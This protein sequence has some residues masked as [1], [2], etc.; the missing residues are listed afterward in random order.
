MQHQ[1]SIISVMCWAG[2][3]L[4]HQQSKKQLN[5][6][7]MEL[8]HFTSRSLVQVCVTRA[9]PAT[10]WVLPSCPHRTKL[11]TP[12]ERLK[13]EQS[14]CLSP[15]DT[16]AAL[17]EMEM[18]LLWPP[19]K[20]ME[21]KATTVRPTT[22]SSASHRDMIHTEKVTSGEEQEGAFLH[23]VTCV[24]LLCRLHVRLQKSLFPGPLRLVPALLCIPL[25]PAQS[26]TANPTA[27]CSKSTSDI[28]PLLLLLQHCKPC[29]IHS[30]WWSW[31]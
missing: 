23:I 19:Q 31:Y 11:C 15:S 17:C 7:G 12:P 9:Q 10:G 29:E 28:P 4:C 2:R 25:A 27:S 18:P 14:E 20:V 8:K 16:P 24:L 22:N 1:Q 3:V 30:V 13:A 26:V 6:P 5:G 21:A